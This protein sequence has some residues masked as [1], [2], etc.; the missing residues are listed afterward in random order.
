[1]HYKQYCKYCK[2]FGVVDDCG[3]VEDTAVGGGVTVVVGTVVGVVSAR[4]KTHSHTQ[5][6][7]GCPA[8][9]LWLTQ[10]WTSITRS[11]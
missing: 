11:G 6:V 1:V 3:G 8:T 5:T 10:T 4:R 2:P 7:I 9:A